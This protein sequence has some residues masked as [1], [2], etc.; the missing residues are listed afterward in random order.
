MPDSA[1]PV[2]ALRRRLAGL[3]HRIR[4][5]SAV[6]GVAR[7]VTSGVVL[8]LA[9]FL[10]D[11]LLDLPI[12]VRRMIRLGL[13]DQP[14]GLA[15]APWLALFLGSLTLALWSG[16]QRLGAAP[17]FAFLT[18]GLV[19]VGLWLGFRLVLPALGPL[20]DERLALA[21]EH[22][23]QGLGDRLAAA[24]DFETE[25]RSPTRGE[26]ESMMRAVLDDAARTAGPLAFGR[27]VS[28]RRAAAWSG[29]AALSVLVAVVVTLAWGDTVALWA[30]R[31][32]GLEDVAWPR[33]TTVLAVDL[34][35]EGAL[36]T[37][38]P[39]RPFEV[40]VGRPFV[41]NA[42][43]EGSVP[44]EVIMRDQ[45]AEGRSLTR[46]LFALAEHPGL[47]RIEIR[48]VR[49]PFSFTLEGGDDVDLAPVYQVEIV[50]PPRVLS[51][52]SRLSFPAYLGRP[53]ETVAGGDLTVPE[54]THVDV[55]VEA[56][57]PVASASAVLTDRV[58]E[59]T[60]TGADG[61]VF[62]FPLEATGPMRYHVRL[63]TS[64]GRESDSASD[65]YEIQV[66]P[67]RP[68]N[69]RWVY[70]HGP[71]EVTPKGR[72][73]LLAVTEDDHA[74][75]ALRL[76]VRLPH[77][78]LATY[79]LTPYTED[80]PGMPERPSLASTATEPTE[81]GPAPA[82][83]RGAGP[84]G[85]Q[86][87]EGTAPPTAGPP[88]DWAAN[89]GPYGRALVR[90]YAPLEIARLAASDAEGLAPPARLSARLVAT[91]SKGQVHEGPWTAIDVFAATDLERGLAGRRN[92]VRT[93]FGV[94][95]SDL[96]AR[97]AQV[98]ELAG[99]S[100]G[101]EGKDLLK[102]VQFAHAKLAQDVEQATAGVLDL[103]DAWIYDRLGA[104]IPTEHVLATLDAY[105]RR[106]Y[107]APPGPGGDAAA[108]PGAPGSDVPS[109]GDPAFPYAL[110]D[111]IVRQ[112]RQKA[113]VDT[114]VLDGLLGVLEPAVEAAARAAP[115]A[116]E[117]ATRAVAGDAT[118]ADLL[119]AED[120]LGRALQE[121][122]ERMRTWQNLHQLVLDLRRLIEEQEALDERLS[123][124]APAAPGETRRP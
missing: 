41:L 115:A 93:A 90:T 46:R 38:P 121:T 7:I 100:V 104:E 123:G 16:R 122:L 28:A 113:F 49:R 86:P 124:T 120:A 3:R 106:T 43:A 34:D 18:G 59:G 35:A 51:V 2:R 101:A 39:E 94:A 52:R 32:L 70:P 36:A 17:L 9:W 78:V 89:D 95:A 91:D 44:D 60:R 21:V 61:R 42:V 65:T 96:Q 33:R 40:V 71:L 55:E 79:A 68:P 98:A 14:A 54:G 110:Y 26:S 23:Y 74:V 45:V 57:V 58:V 50:V 25:L 85:P 119:A 8:L 105:H 99:G 76:E 108:S 84:D 88:P 12:G 75:A 77:D 92:S 87:A 29:A 47:F 81:P 114:G 56:D 5:L 30:R 112:W 116:H 19:G 82:P 24:L 83:P 111:T 67:D 53:Q 109:A 69:V 31:S 117:T 10:A 118:P 62:T 15:T 107:G 64:G 48:D 102:S 22:R 20:P 66:E 27:A 4:T 6:Q 97:R 37:H 72:I 63:T 103:F 1:S 80:A 11:W 73:P 13:L